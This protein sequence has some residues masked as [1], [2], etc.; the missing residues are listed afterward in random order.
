MMV[1]FSREQDAASAKICEKFIEGVN[2]VML[3]AQ[4]QSGKSTTFMHVMLTLLFKEVFTQVYIITGNRD[5][6]LR[7]QTEK[8]VG[9][10]VDYFARSIVSD[11]PERYSPSNIGVIR[12]KLRGDIK[13]AYG[14]DISKLGRIEENTL[15][16]H[17]ESHYA[18]DHGNT[19]YDKFY[20]RE[21]IQSLLSNGSS[22]R[23]D[24]RLAIL[25]VSAT[26]FSEMISNN[27]TND[28]RKPIV[29]L[30]PAPGYRGVGHYL[31]NGL[32]HE[33]FPI[34]E[35][36]THLLRHII[37]EQKR[38]NPQS[39]IIIRSLNNKG[40]AGIL[41]RITRE[42]GINFEHYYGNG[43]ISNLFR[44]ESIPFDNLKEIPMTLTIIHICGKLRMGQVLHH[45][46]HISIVF[47][48]SKNPNLDTV[49]QGLLGRMC[50]Y[51]DIDIIVYI[52]RR[53]IP[54][55]RKYY[56]MM[57]EDNDSL[58]TTNRKL[59][60]MNVT[61]KNS[62]ERRQ[63]HDTVHTT[64]NGREF[65][66]IPPIRIR[67]ELGHLLDVREYDRFKQEIE[68]NNLLRYFNP[69]QKAEFME[70]LD[71]TTKRWRDGRNMN[72]SSYVE[73][74]DV[75]NIM[76]CIREGNPCKTLFTNMLERGQYLELL[77][78]GV[79]PNQAYID[80]GVREG[81]LLI[82]GFTEH[83]TEEDEARRRRASMV[84]TTKDKC[85]FKRVAPQ[86]DTPPQPEI[87]T[88]ATMSVLTNDAMRDA[89]KMVRELTNI[90][91]C[92]IP[93]HPRD[94]PDSTYNPQIPRCISS[95]NTTYDMEPI[96]IRLRLQNE[97]RNLVIRLKKKGGRTPANTEFVFRYKSITW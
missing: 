59:K 51:H 61:P 4:M 43:D 34:K 73:R 81:D 9:D 94:N 26:P 13:I 5:V 1:V 25:S 89:D 58:I 16:I 64:E 86:D 63:N 83:T 50:G 56:E 80:A 15:I 82:I 91:K 65:F 70:Y 24:H 23:N 49:L 7:S 45:K 75:Q 76:R 52:S 39:Y 87:S 30:R 19:T 21:Q 3:L 68:D 77:H 54:E 53:I 8:D 84:L 57:E 20:V 38:T 33:S 17:D 46:E 32:I 88:N 66:A 95:I 40:Q 93:Y 72:H 41:R 60:S 55:V 22:S 2:Y 47:E 97:F 71:D 42:L 48:S 37:E 10:H 69:V 27:N 18:Q 85:V 11:N 78:F 67:G 90:I 74:G 28:E 36:N 31:D 12:R 96:M 29:K 6:S 92:T 14:Q 62:S 44:G 35:E 79:V